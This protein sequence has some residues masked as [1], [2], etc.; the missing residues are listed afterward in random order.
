VAERSHSPKRTGFGVFELDLRAG[1]LRKGG[2]RVKLQDQP[3]QVLA[4]LLERPGEV[5]TREELQHR[6]WPADT[7]VDFEHGINVAVRRLREALEDSAETPR[8]VETL[9]RHG[10]RFIAP[11]EQPTRSARMRQ[12]WIAAIGAAALVVLV[13]AAAFFYFRPAQGLTESD[14]ILL[15]DFVN[16]TGESVFDGTL[17]QALAV[18][19][20]ES[21]FLNI[22]PER[23]VRETLRFMNRSVDEPVTA[24]IGREVCQRQGVKA[25][26]ISEIAV[27]G[28]HYVITLD[29]E[30]C[31]T[32][33]SLARE[34]VEA[35]SKEEVLRGLG[36]AISR[37]RGKL[38]E[39]LN[40]IEKHDVPIEQATTS[41][42][43]A[44]KAFS[45]GNAL[46]TTGQAAESIPFYKRAIELDP[47]FALAYAHLGHELNIGESELVRQ[48]QEKAF[49]LRERVSEREKLNITAHHYDSVTGDIEKARETCELWR[50]IY[51]RD[52][53]ARINLANLYNRTGQYEK[54]IEEAKDALRLDPD[55]VF[56][57]RELGLAYRGLNRFDEAKAV[58]ERLLTKY[59]D[60][61][62]GHFGLYIIA[63]IQ[64]DLAAMRHQ[65]E[66][67]KDRPAGVG[68]LMLAME[69]QEAAFSGQLREA[70]A[71]FRQ[72][73]DL[74]LGYDLR[75][76]VPGAVAREAVNEALFGNFQRARE[77]AVMALDLA[78]TRVTLL[79]AA[80][81]LARSSDVSRT[82]APIQELEQQFRT[83]TLLRTVYLPSLRAILLVRRDNPARA[84]ELLQTAARY[85]RAYLGVNLV[86]GQAY[87]AQGNGVMAVNL[88]RGQAYLAQGNGVMAAAEFQKILDQRGVDSLSL[89]HPLAALGLARAYAQQGDTDGARQ[90]YEDFLTLWRDADPDIPILQEAQAEYA[91]LQEPETSVPTN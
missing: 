54:A 41:S 71:L 68:V 25:I 11:V 8:F 35:R 53:I 78:R 73:G 16:A 82:E 28:S 86:R 74:A 81:A 64:G 77:R 57:Y 62:Y 90:A 24:S 20:E 48:Y 3:L 83:D 91:K 49:E 4:M 23:R 66:W 80:F 70:R 58:Y 6:L 45:Q 50:Q 2:V 14:Y 55:S 27:L 40:S 59:P 60:A 10:Y 65:R 43:E 51:P 18:K 37:L 44:L 61:P 52:S 31:H 21:P 5:V 15:T 87:L 19:L 33:D 56:P 30:D 89:V 1:E 63:F 69:A 36:Q 9:P 39:A 13:A 46:W 79:N 75:A 88:V 67:A 42:L 85:E 72:A 76:W 32:G 22:V 84:I 47:N 38:G 26:M 29:A 7:F 17:K 12:V 34:Q